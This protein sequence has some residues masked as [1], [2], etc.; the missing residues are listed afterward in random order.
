LS[1]VRAE[2][3]L[4]T[5]IQ[6]IDLINCQTCPKHDN[7]PIINTKTTNITVQILVRQKTLA[8][9]A[10]M[11]KMPTQTNASTTSIDVIWRIGKK[12]F[13]VPASLS[14]VAITSNLFVVCYL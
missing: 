6:L 11:R 13:R 2:F 8:P 3:R 9:P 12:T 14:P 1:H 4:Q 5:S 10:E 7:T